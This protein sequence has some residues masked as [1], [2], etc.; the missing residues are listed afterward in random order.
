MGS[1][2]Y[3]RAKLSGVDVSPWVGGSVFSHR[4]INP[5]IPTLPY[6]TE[7]ATPTVTTWIIGAQVV[8]YK[9]T[10]PRN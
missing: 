6:W 7:P 10:L 3:F 4:H 9:A 1:L 8:W 2:A 5:K